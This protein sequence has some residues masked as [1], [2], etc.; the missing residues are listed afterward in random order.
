MRCCRV[1]SGRICLVYISRVRQE[2]RGP[3]KNFN[4]LTLFGWDGDGGMNERVN[5]SRK[6]KRVRRLELWLGWAGAAI[7]AVIKSSY[8]NW[9]VTGNCCLQALRPLCHFNYLWRPDSKAINNNLS[10]SHHTKSC[11]ASSADIVRVTGGS[12]LQKTYIFACLVTLVIH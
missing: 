6:K 3:R 2:E 11:P 1:R 8:L 4:K 7:A 5:K 9:D 12:G 10:L